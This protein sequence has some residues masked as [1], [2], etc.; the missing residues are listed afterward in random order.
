MKKLTREEACIE[1]ARRMGLDA[2][3]PPPNYFKSHEAVASLVIWLSEQTDTSICENFERALIKI[4]MGVS[5]ELEDAYLSTL[6]WLPLTAKP[7]QIARAAC[8]ALGIEL[9]EQPK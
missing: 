1:L 8:A 6:F 2:E 3:T 9:Q 7:E 5:Y 4:R